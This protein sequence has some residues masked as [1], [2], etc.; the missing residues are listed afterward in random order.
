M[1][2]LEENPGK[3]IMPTSLFPNIKLD[4]YK[5]VFCMYHHPDGWLNPDKKRE[6]VDYIRAS[7]D[8]ILVGHEH[9]RDSYKTEGASFSVFCQ[10][11]CN[12]IH[13]TPREATLS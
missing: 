8:M 5:V 7:A 1:S 9:D 6:F 2:I 13:F 10:P 4:E 3:I 11:D 12:R